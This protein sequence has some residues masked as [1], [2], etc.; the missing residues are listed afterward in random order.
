MLFIKCVL[1]LCTIMSCVIQHVVGKATAHQRMLNWIHNSG[2]YVHPAIKA[3]Y[4]S[5]MGVGLVACEPIKAHEVL[6][7]VPDSMCFVDNCIDDM[8]TKLA[9]E[10]QF[11]D[12]SSV[13]PF[14]ATLPTDIGSLPCFWENKLVEELKGTMLAQ[15]TLKMRKQ[16]ELE[17]K[18]RT[19]EHNEY[20]QQHS[21]RSDREE[22]LSEEEWMWA[23]GTLQSR[24]FKFQEEIAFIPFVSACNHNDKKHCIV[25]RGDDHSHPKQN[26]LLESRAK[27]Y[28]GE[29]VCIS[30]G[31]ISFQQKLLSFGWIDDETEFPHNFS[32][33]C[34]DIPASSLTPR[35]KRSGAADFSLEIPTYVRGDS[36][37]TYKKNRQALR[38]AVT[39]I[40]NFM[41]SNED[42]SAASDINDNRCPKTV[43]VTALTKRLKSIV[44]KDCVSTEWICNDTEGND[45]DL[46]TMDYCLDSDSDPMTTIRRME[47]DSVQALLRELHSI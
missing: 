2:G 42:S 28:P 38:E 47:H 29:Q 45:D 6:I 26:F 8:A 1:S 35:K 37:S 15:D 24:A 18:K 36:E 39:A 7:S 23:R 19:R 33:V 12:S 43:L 40:K 20:V 31:D 41:S 34:L 5:E 14:L 30:Y 44:T 21:Y 9:K 25:R 17:A 22:L 10:L 3:E 4:F 32:L 27:Y 11:A 16:W 13:S 46:C